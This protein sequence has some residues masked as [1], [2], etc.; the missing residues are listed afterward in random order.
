MMRS[1]FGTILLCLFC[2]VV[3]KGVECSE[4]AVDLSKRIDVGVGYPYLSLK[5]GFSPKLT[6]ELK[7]AFG[8]GVSVLSGRGY[9]NLYST[10]RILGFGGG[11]LGYITFDTGGTKGSGY[12]LMPFVGGEYFITQNLGLGLDLGLGYVIL[13]TREAARDFDIGGMEWISNLGLSYYFGQ[14]LKPVAPPAAEFEE[15]S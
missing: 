1:L 13:K 3:A 11:E 5:Y 2:M 8:E 10:A 4:S 7:G 6:G 15:E 9:Y 14:R 12:L